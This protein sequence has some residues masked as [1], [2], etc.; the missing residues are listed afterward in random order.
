MNRVFLGGMRGL[1]G[2]GACSFSFLLKCLGLLSGL[3]V[4][5]I[6]S[7]NSKIQEGGNL[8]FACHVTGSP[9][10]K[11][12]W[13]TEGLHS[14]YSTQV[15]SNVLNIYIFFLLK[16]LITDLLKQTRKRGKMS[17]AL[18]LSFHR[19][20]QIFFPSHFFPR[21]MLQIVRP[22]TNEDVWPTAKTN[23]PYRDSSPEI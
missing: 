16:L 23:N 9:R 6:S 18:S 20:R 4:V 1:G 10:P 8:T 19:L 14:H 12:R 3:P 7:S 15:V 22:L 11:A 17:H 5:A 13:R 2:A 21:R